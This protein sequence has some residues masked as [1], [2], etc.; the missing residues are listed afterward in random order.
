VVEQR[1]GELFAGQIFVTNPL[2][3]LPNNNRAR[4]VDC[5]IPPERN[6]APTFAKPPLPSESSI[7]Q[8]KHAQG[9]GVI[10]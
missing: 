3:S 5:I 10:C 6:C 7:N 8:T 2:Q 4:A 9:W 1:S